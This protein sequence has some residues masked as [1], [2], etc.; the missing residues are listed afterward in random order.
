MLLLVFQL[1]KVR[2]QASLVLGLLLE[3]VVVVVVLLLVVLGRNNSQAAAANS[4]TTTTAKS[5]NG[6][7]V[8]LDSGFIKQ[9]LANSAESQVSRSI[10]RGGSNSNFC[11]P[12]RV[13]LSMAE[14][15]TQ[16][17][18]PAPATNPVGS[19]PAPTKRLTAGHWGWLLLLVALLGFTPLRMLWPL[20][21]ITLGFLVLAKRLS[22]QVGLFMAFVGFAASVFGSGG[23]S[24]DQAAACLLPELDWRGLETLEV[25]LDNSQLQLDSGQAQQV[26]IRCLGNGRLE[27]SRQGNSLLLVFSNVE[28]RL[29]ADFSRT[30][31]TFSGNNNTLSLSGQLQKLN[32]ENTNGGIRL[33]QVQ[34]AN[35][36]I[37]TSNAPI[38]ISQSTL[39]IIAHNANA[40]II[41]KNSQNSQ[42]RLAT[43]ND[44][45][46]V[47]DSSGVFDIINSNGDIS[48]RQ[49]SS[50]SIQLDAKNGAIELDQVMLAAGSSNGIH[51]HEGALLLR[52]VGATQGLSVYSGGSTERL[53]VSA[54]KTPS[55]SGQNDNTVLAQPGP[56]PAK[57]QLQGSGEV[58][59]E[60]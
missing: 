35:S 36:R 10:C 52:K 57:L 6:G 24:G 46:E 42:F 28:A 11:L 20:L 30:N 55:K 14:V 33:R 3:A 41:I 8:G 40:A 1:L 27:A 26:Q 13:P 7:R 53:K 5:A 58:R 12:A 29:A 15:N 34:A 37:E 2:F 23:R 19:R 56:N 21:F 50:A 9:S 45:I 48:L 39:N 25:L 16:P 47:V 54:A 22:G 32:I 4:K 59:L 51:Y 31:V 17:V 60:D 18:P 43:T 44:G 38:E 49:I